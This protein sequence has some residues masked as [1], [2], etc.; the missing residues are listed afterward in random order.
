MPIRTATVRL[1]PLLPLLL[2]AIGAAVRAESPPRPPN[3][4]F[5]A[6]DDLR[7]EL[8]CYGNAAIHSPN[9]D[10][11]CSEGMAFDRAYCQ[12]AVC[13][14]SRT[15]LLTGLRPDATRVH[16]LQ[17]HFRDTVEDVVTLPQQF[18]EHGYQAEWW[19]KIYHAALLD[20]PSWTRQ[21]ERYEP[22]DNWR[23][24]QLPSSNELAAQNDGG[25]PPFESADVPDDAYPDGKVA[26]SAIEALRRLRDEPFFLAVGF[27]KPHLPFTAPKKYWDLYDPGSIS[28]PEM[29]EPP[30]GSPRVAQTAW[31]ELRAYSQ[32]PPAGRLDEVMTRRLIHGYR[33]CVSYTD[34]QIGRLLDELDR[35]DLRENT[36]VVL[37]GDH[38]W[39]LGDYGEWCKHTNFEIDTRVPLIVSAPGMK[40]KGRRTSALVEYVDVYPSLCE[41]AGLPLPVHLQGESFAPLLDDPS[42]ALKQAAYSQFPRPHGVMGYSVRTANHRFTA[43]L[44]AEHRVIAQELYD[45]SNGL[46]ESINT[47]QTP[48]GQAVSARLLT[49][50]EQDL[51]VLIDHN[52][53]GARAQ[54][55]NSTPTV[56][57]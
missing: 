28:L 19:G 3:V 22:V 51:G 13:S 40:A 31:G 4:L 26:D 27:Y 8:G 36:I 12:Q 9:I 7:P 17:T 2:G 37:W 45:H 35:L 10:R 29:S 6:V 50:I 56:A 32:I 53:T 5:I 48:E 16:D 39:K 38:G 20:P 46:E 14:P 44:D 57:F 34:A 30:T 15:S 11:L 42:L 54:E 24:Y 18:K 23:A 25:G 52:A 43:W 55:D 1:M 41:L 49:R 47:A 33:A 21:G